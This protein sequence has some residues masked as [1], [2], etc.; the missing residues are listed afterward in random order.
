[1]S[2]AAL[3]AGRAAHF[4][5][6]ALGHVT[7]EY[8]H[9]LDHVMAGA[10]DVRSPQ[11]LHP[12]FYGSFDWHSCVHGHWL[13]ARVARTFPDLPES[14][15]IRALFERQFTGAKV[16][17]EV[18][19]LAD[20]SSR[21]FER[22]YG[23]AWLL[24]LAGELAKWDDPAGRRWAQTLAPLAEAFVQRFLTYLPLAGYPIRSG[25]HSS[26]A[27]ALL[28]A[29]EFADA[30]GHGSLREMLDAKAHAWFRA[31]TDCQAWEPGGDDF[32]SP[33]LME[34]ALL[35]VVLPPD[36]F[37]G[38]LTAFLPRLDRREPATLFFPARVSDRTD[39]KIAH[40]DGLNLSRAWCWG[41]LGRALPSADPRRRLAE[42]AA[43]DHL[44][45]ALPHVSGDYAGEHWLAT[46]ALLALEA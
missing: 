18:A 6:I 21:T 38:W 37:S 41:L 34:A 4:A 43:A 25:S 32:L 7:R 44:A 22:P 39:G 3:D 45:A 5:R 20:P 40:L 12:L 28:L 19:Y 15:E 36:G 27:F 30:T 16:A 42:V 26:S 10:A 46:F 35:S 9:K 2:V 31:D 8:P 1:M 33:A 14:E 23:W 24:K 13:L 11:A 29:R 17:G